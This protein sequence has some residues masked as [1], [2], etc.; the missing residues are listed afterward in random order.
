MQGLKIP[1]SNRHEAKM[2]VTC[3]LSIIYLPEGRKFILF[4]MDTSGFKYQN[5]IG[6]AAEPLVQDPVAISFDGDGRLWVVEM[7]GFMAD[8]DGTGGLEKVDRISIL[9]DE[10]LGGRMDRSTIFLDSPVFDID[11]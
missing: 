11:M 1:D 4:L 2:N 7:L 5:R 8:I 10:D 9:F 6:I 3:I